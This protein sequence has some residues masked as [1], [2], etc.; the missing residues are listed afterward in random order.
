MSDEIKELVIQP[1]GVLVTDILNVISENV[2]VNAPYIRSLISD[3][4]DKLSNAILSV[5]V[6]KQA[7]TVQCTSL[8]QF[9]NLIHFI[10]SRFYI[11]LNPYMSPPQ[12]KS[13]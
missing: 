1:D 2:P 13:P 9:E 7:T 5:E 6:F 11:T 4:R 10:A 8:M 12:E 3:A